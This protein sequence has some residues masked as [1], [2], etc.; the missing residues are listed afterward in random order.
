MHIVGPERGARDQKITAPIITLRAS[1]SVDA[2]LFY[3]ITEQ[4]MRPYV[5][6][7]GG[8]WE[9]ES[10]RKEAAED[11]INPGASVILVNAAEAGILAVEKLTSELRLHMLYLLPSF[12]GLGVGS[13]LVSS[14]Q[15]EAS[16]RGV[17]LRLQVLKVNPAKAF[18]E[19]LGFR[20]E[21]ES[22]YFFHMQCSSS[23]LVWPAASEPKSGSCPSVVGR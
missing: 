3:S 6:V 22:E 1:Q 7:A 16:S 18:Y 13:A 4:T 5:I 12:Q 19:R 14:L 15:K 9:E 21:E 2:E 11:A 17:P 10:R 20:I 8:T 23:Y